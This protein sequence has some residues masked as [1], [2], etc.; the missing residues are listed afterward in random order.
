VGVRR[1]FELFTDCGIDATLF[2][3]GED[4]EVDAHRQRLRDGSATGHELANHTYSHLYDLRSRHFR[5]QRDEILRAHEAIADLT[6]QPP[7]GFRAPGY[8]IAEDLLEICADAG[9]RY[10]ASIFPCPPYYVAKAAV[11]TWLMARGRPSRSAMTPFRNLFA[12]L[13]PYQP[14]LP[15]Y[16]APNAGEAR[17][18]EVPIAVIPWL[19]FPLIVTSLHLLGSRG[20]D[21]I[22]GA[23]TKAYPRVFNLEFH[24]I[25]FMDATDPGV[26]DLVR[27]QPDLA[28][29]WAQKR[30][31]YVHVFNRMREVYRFAPI[32]DAVTQLR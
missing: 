32:R 7:V 8:N 23:L 13:T 25:D 22:F 17:L 14:S 27:I 11:M 12:P 3:I 1:L 31:L 6:G 21:A 5:E 15:R 20:F 9:Y 29:P 2:V 10:D 24:A 19:R 18:W 16:W 28:I 4:L 30:A 26:E